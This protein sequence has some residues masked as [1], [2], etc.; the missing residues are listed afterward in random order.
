[1]QKGRKKCCILA[2]DKIKHPSLKEGSEPELIGA[3]V[4][5]VWENCMSVRRVILVLLEIDYI[6]QLPTVILHQDIIVQSCYRALH[7][8]AALLAF[9]CSMKARIA[10]EVSIKENSKR[11][12]RRRKEGKRLGWKFPAKVFMAVCHLLFF[13][14]KGKSKASI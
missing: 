12:W 1:M 5:G 10:T 3:G 13:L 7:Y 9:Q 8:R 11:K 6:P 2:L 4:S 14:P